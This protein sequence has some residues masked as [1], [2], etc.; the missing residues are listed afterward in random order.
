IH[1]N[2]RFTIL[3]NK[4]TET[5]STQDDTCLILIGSG[6]AF[7]DYPRTPQYCATKWAMRRIM[8][9]LRRT[10][11][12]YG[13]CVN[14]ISPWYANLDGLCRYYGEGQQKVMMASMA[15]RTS[16][17]PTIAQAQAHARTR[18]VFRSEDPNPQLPPRD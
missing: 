7:L 3:S 10:A 14:V 8:H 12:N 17:V 9:S 5:P 6:A 16:G 4:W 11:F 18:T 1:S 13:S 15:R 2:C